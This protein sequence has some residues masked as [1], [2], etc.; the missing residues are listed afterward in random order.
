MMQATRFR[1]LTTAPRR[2]NG[3]VSRRIPQHPLKGFLERIAMPPGATSLICINGH[4]FSAG[5]MLQ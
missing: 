2:L 5:S 1:N 4:E 3:V